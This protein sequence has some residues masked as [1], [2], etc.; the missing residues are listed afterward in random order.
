[1]KRLWQIGRAAMARTLR[2]YLFIVS[3]ASQVLGALVLA[4]VM[5]LASFAGAQAL[6]ATSLTI[7]PSPNASVFSE[8][9]TFTVTISSATGTGTPTGTVTFSD[10]IGTIGSAPA[11]AG[12]GTGQAQATFSTTALPVGN[13]IITAT[14]GGDNNFS[15]SSIPTPFTVAEAGDQTAITSSS[16]TITFGQSV[17]F[18]VTVSPTAP[19]T[20]TPTGD[21]D[22]EWQSNHPDAQ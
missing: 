3:R 2:G 7:L 18:T 1:V 21:S 19:A 20:G 15:G 8:S 13:L 9:V 4:S 12:P 5:L 11:V 14:Y 17:T 6:T 16:N 10:G 22:S